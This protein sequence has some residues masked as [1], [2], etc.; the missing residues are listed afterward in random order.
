ML[1]VNGPEQCLEGHCLSKTST[2]TDTPWTYLNVACIARI[3][4]CYPIHARAR[5]LLMNA[6]PKVSVSV[7]DGPTDP[8]DY[9]S[10][11]TA[12]L[13]VCA[14]HLNNG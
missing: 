7:V 13:I 2:N 12:N 1:G 3:Y 9:N 14:Q 8:S 11:V 5:A 4:M 6:H 10:L